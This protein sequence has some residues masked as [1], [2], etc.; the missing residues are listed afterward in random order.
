M[1]VRKRSLDLSNESFYLV[2]SVEFGQRI[3]NLYRLGQHI[4]LRQVPAPQ[5]IPVSNELFVSSGVSHSYLLRL[6]WFRRWRPENTGD[7]RSPSP[8]IA[9]ANNRIG[10]NPC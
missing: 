3:N 7:Q 9:N 5:G 6:L 8:F 2:A 4:E 1:N 10:A